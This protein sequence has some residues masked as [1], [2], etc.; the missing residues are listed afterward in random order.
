MNTDC[1]LYTLPQIES[2][3]STDTDSDESDLEVTSVVDETENIAISIMNHFNLG[4][5]DD[6]ENRINIRHKFQTY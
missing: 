6:D 1:H 3:D 4:N 5:D 2:D